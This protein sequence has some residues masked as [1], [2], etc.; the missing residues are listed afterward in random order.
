MTNNVINNLIKNDN[1]KAG[2]VGL[3]GQPN[4]GKSTLLNV[5]VNEKV[6]IVTPK[7]QTTRRRVLGIH[8]FTKGQVVLVDAPGI[9]ASAKG[10]NSFLEA[11][12]KEVVKE[13][14]V[15]C[16]VLNLDQH[17]KEDL[18]LVLKWVTSSKRPWFAVLT[19]VDLVKYFHRKEMIKAQIKQEFPEVRIFEF[20]E[21][22]GSDLEEFRSLFFEESLRLL[23]KM[24]GPLYDVELFTPHHTRELVAEMIRE[25]CFETLSHE[26]PY[27]LA[28]RI[29]SF[30]EDEKITR[31]EADIVV[32][33]DNHKAMVIGSQA[34]KIKEIGTLARESI[35]GLLDQKV[36]LK[37]TVVVREN[38][39]E[40]HLIMKE[41]GYVSDTK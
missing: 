39:M 29:R 19:K 27:Q 20:S 15:L 6:S 9:V 21:T 11:E 1:Y 34:S 2:F 38:W 17:D 25:K 32:G 18:D 3:I 5:L 40:N 30:K 33:K 35:E 10:L 31:I 26:L 37:L 4:A 23:P 41:L 8:S 14:D 13:S 36:F 7:P 22:W 28:I 24:P 16:A 12:A